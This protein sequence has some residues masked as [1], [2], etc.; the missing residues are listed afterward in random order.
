VHEI[1]QKEVLNRWRSS[2]SEGGS[3][4]RRS[5]TTRRRGRTLRGPVG[6]LCCGFL[7]TV[8]YLLGT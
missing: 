3:I 4:I 2:K 5:R 7:P 6:D 1:L 8:V